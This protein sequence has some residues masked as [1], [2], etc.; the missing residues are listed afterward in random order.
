[1]GQYIEHIYIRQTEGVINNQ[2]MQNWKTLQGTGI[3]AYYF[4]PDE[5][6]ALTPKTN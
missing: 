2:Q 3:E 1:M 5:I 6:H 4:E